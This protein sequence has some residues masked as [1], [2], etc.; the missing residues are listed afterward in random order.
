M[1]SCYNVQLHCWIDWTEAPRPSR[2]ETQPSVAGVCVCVSAPGMSVSDR[3]RRRRRGMTTLQELCLD[4]LSVHASAL[5]DLG[6]LPDAIV[7]EILRRSSLAPTQLVLLEKANA[8][9]DISHL[10]AP[11]WREACIGELKISPTELKPPY[12]ALYRRTKEAERLLLKSS[13]AAIARKSQHAAEARSCLPAHKGRLGGSVAKTSASSKRSAKMNT[14]SKLIA[15]VRSDPGPRK[16]REVRATK[17]KTLKR[18]ISTSSV[19][20]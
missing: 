5:G 15:R 12:S 4:K 14:L 20:D 7:A 16:S 6:D 19:F 9:R 13:M 2:A 1:L 10:T 11:L 17:A 3:V 18:T 8:A